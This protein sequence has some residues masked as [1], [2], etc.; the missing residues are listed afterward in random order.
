MVFLSRVPIV[1][2]NILVNQVFSQ[3]IYH[4]LKTMNI[5][6]EEP[7]KAFFAGFPQPFPPLASFPFS[8][9]PTRRKERESCECKLAGL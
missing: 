8:S 3:I 9:L 5:R 7:A 2:V 6:E 1:K 4:L